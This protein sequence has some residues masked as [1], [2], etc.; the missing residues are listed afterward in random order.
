[1]TRDA[2][3]VYLLE[4]LDAALAASEIIPFRVIQS[5]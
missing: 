5:G 2:Y 1:M 4:R 3:Y